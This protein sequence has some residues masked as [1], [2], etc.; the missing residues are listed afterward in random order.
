MV[1]RNETRVD[2]AIHD[3]SDVYARPIDVVND[4]RPGTDRTYPVS[5][6]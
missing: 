2:S 4:A 6:P 3:P 1:H 5:G